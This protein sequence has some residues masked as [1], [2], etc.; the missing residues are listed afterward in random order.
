MD[1]IGLMSPSRFLVGGVIM[2]AFLMLLQYILAI[3]KPSIGITCEEIHVHPPLV[4]KALPILGHT[5]IR[6]LWDPLGFSHTY[7]YH[8]VPIMND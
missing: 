5:P 3:V 4:P 8:L 2:S 1:A 6:F 7:V